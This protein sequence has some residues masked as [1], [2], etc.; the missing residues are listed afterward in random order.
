M[1]PDFQVDTEGLHR[2]ATAIAAFADRITGAGTSAPV[3]EAAPHWATTTATTLAA[4]S[5]RR[6]VR[7]LG[8]DTGQTAARMEASA[9]AYREADARAAARLAGAGAP[10]ET[11]GGTRTSR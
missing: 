4:E 10:P 2:D 7:L 3:A 11:P 8:H 6:M 5:A 1:N 9:A